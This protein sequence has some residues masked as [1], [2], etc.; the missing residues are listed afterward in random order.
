[1][2]RETVGLVRYAYTSSQP[3]DRR[4]EKKIKSSTLV[5]DYLYRC[6]II[7]V[8]AVQGSNCVCHTTSNAPV[9]SPPYQWRLLC[10]HRMKSVRREGR[11]STRYQVHVT[12]LWKKFYRCCS[13]GSWI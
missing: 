4:P 7:W 1:M 11:T 8:Q 2:D 6:T 12:V 13:Y 10:D 3:D 9:G 5:N